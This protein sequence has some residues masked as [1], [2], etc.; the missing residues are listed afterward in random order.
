MSASTQI[1]QTIA[2]NS[3]FRTIIEGT[4]LLSGVLL[5]IILA[6]LL[7]PN[8]Y[9]RLSFV[10]ALM[11]FFT[12]GIN[13]GLPLTFV[14]NGAR[15]MGFLHE[16][17]ATGLALQCI[18]SF[19]MF[20]VLG[21]M[22]ISFSSLRQ[23]TILLIAAFIYTALSVIA[24]F[25][26]SFFQ[27]VQKMHLEAVA[28]MI[29]NTL[30]FAVVLVLLFLKGTAEAALWGYTI[31]SLLSV[32]VTAMLIRKYLFVWKWEVDWRAGL[33]LLTQSWPLMASM[34]FGSIYHSLDIIML[35]FFQGNEAV[36]I[37]SAQYRIVFTF[38]IFAGWY[39]YSIFPLLSNL[40]MNAREQFRHLV[41][42]SVQHMTAFAYLFGL[43]IT[44]FARP[45]VRLLYGEMYLG[46]IFVL[47]ILI[48][49][50]MVALV[51]TI[52]Y[53]ALVA[54]EKQRQV[55]KSVVIGTIINALLNFM[56][57]PI[58]GMAG[59]ALATVI[60]Q[61]V[62]FGLNLRV[63]RTIVPIQLLHLVI[64]PTIYAG[65]SV[66]IYFILAS[67]V[68]PA[69]AGVIGLGS[70]ISAL[71]FGKVFQWKE[72]RQMILVSLHNRP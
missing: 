72:L 26:H 57:I 60:T 51:G 34:A 19:I 16:N 44:F 40:F 64:K 22:I 13:L 42:R 63:L 11:T 53:H 20:F 69:V 59:A 6:R 46:G 17:L 5:V 58:L 25:F 9:G 67:L 39:V 27:A 24:N 52:F 45:L 32:F 68:L 50:I 12:V 29:Q 28:V 14:R 18:A 48:W 41:E 70:Y 71:F 1:F 55:L 47:Q 35:R 15:R 8:E 65:G 36:G 38:Y 4:K 23:D 31:A 30:I 21:I 56:M 66:A 3:F 37:Y 61:G 49:S 7:G 62:Q 43:G 33:T 2:H 10:L 54:A